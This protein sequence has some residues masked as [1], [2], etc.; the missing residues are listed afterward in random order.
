MCEEGGGELWDFGMQR[1]VPQN[2]CWVTQTS[3]IDF[4]Y[5]P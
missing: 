3:H 1:G 2:L 5:A 4:S